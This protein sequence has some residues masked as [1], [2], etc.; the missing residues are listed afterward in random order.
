MIQ[1]LLMDWGYFFSC[2]SYVQSAVPILWKPESFISSL[3]IFNI[4]YVVILIATFPR[5][6]VEICG[7]LSREWSKYN[8]KQTFFLLKKNHV[9][10]VLHILTVGSGCWR[11]LYFK[12][13][14]QFKLSFQFSKNELE[15]QFGN[16][17][18]RKVITSGQGWRLS[19]FL[20][21]SRG[22]TAPL[23]A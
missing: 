8:L 6:H 3:I 15:I 13:F 21:L 18:S 9:C 7:L 20:G 16:V 22:S 5:F 11:I 1:H 17:V 14:I 19:T 10:F 12:P 23:F 2:Q 4:S